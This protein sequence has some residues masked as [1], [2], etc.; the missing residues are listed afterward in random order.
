MIRLYR[1]PWSTNCERVG[2]ALA[3]KGLEA[4]SVLID[5][6]DRSPVV[7]AS[8]QGLVPVIE[9][10]PDVIADS[11][12]IL[13]HLDRR[14]P[15]DPLYPPE[16]GERARVELFCEWFDR[17]WKVAP[18]LIE[19]ELEKGDPGHEAITASA[20]TMMR[21][22]DLFDALLEDRPF[23]AGAEV[24]AADFVA[25]PFLKYAA[26]RD[27]ADGELFHRVLDERQSL[28]GRPRLAEWLERVR[29]L[30][31]AYEETNLRD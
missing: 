16:R 22:L 20:Q 5:Y 26:G 11:R 23:L 8:G 2:L 7:A 12:R 21:H 28:D 1:A 19:A 25:Y 29:V 17:V 14:Y 30:P 24:T 18:N 15:D 27:P 6:A 10:G 31:R 4:E 9:D 3:H 13:A